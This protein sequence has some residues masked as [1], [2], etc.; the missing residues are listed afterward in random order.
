MIE[1]IRT[2]KGFEYIPDGRYTLEVT[3]IPEKIKTAKGSSRK[4]VFNASNES[5]YNNKIYVY[6][7]PWMS[8]ELILALGGKEI[9]ENELEW[10]DE[11][12]VG[13]LVEADVKTESYMGKDKNGNET[14][15]KKYILSN[16]KPTSEIPF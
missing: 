4:W 9:N 3:E 10:D 13:L 15:K 5:I 11:K 7:M 14:T 6:L 1:T 12:V 2:D 8:R 16:V